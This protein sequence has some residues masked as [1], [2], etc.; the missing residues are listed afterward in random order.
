MCRLYTQ[1]RR[2]PSCMKILWQQT[3][4]YDSCKTPCP[5]KSCSVVRYGDNGKDASEKDHHTT[6]QHT[7][8]CPEAKVVQGTPVWASQDCGFCQWQRTVEVRRKW[9]GMHFMQLNT[10]DINERR[11]VSA[12]MNI[13]GST[14]EAAGETSP[15]VVSDLSE[16][17]GS[18]S[19]DSGSS[20]GGGTQRRKKSVRF[21][22]PLKVEKKRSSFMAR[23]TR[24][25]S[26]SN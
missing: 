20:Q 22:E 2:C 8:A 7:I 6:L 23:F 14:T 16:G 19:I 18:P 26:R 21:A 12:P 13:T 17:S 24:D 10:F 11:T 3:I 9:H 15:S 5:C 25:R 1:T 4:M